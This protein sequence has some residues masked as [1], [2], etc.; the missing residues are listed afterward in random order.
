MSQDTFAA[1]LNRQSQKVLETAE[2]AVSHLIALADALHMPVARDLLEASLDGL[3]RPSFTM[4]IFGR[5]STGKSTLINVLLGRLQRPLQDLPG[6]TGAPLPMDDMPVNARV[7]T[8]RYA[9][10]PT[11]T[12][13]RTDGSRDKRSLAWFIQNSPLRATHQ[14]SIDAFRDI[15]QFELTYPFENGKAGIILVDTPG[16]DEA[17]ERDIVALKA[18][19][20]ADAAILMFQTGGLAGKE[21]LSFARRMLDLGLTSYFTVINRWNGK[22]IDE[23]F[24]RFAWDK[25]VREL[26]QGP[27]FAADRFAD[28]RVYFVDALAA[29][30]GRLNDD[31]AK[32]RAS[33]IVELESA[34]ARFYEV[35]RRKV[36][37]Q[38]WADQA[39][40]QAAQMSSFIR[41]QIPHLTA[42]HSDFQRSYEEAGPRLKELTAR[43]GQPAK[44]FARFRDRAQATLLG[45]LQQLIVRISDEIG[46]LLEKQELKSVQGIGAILWAAMSKEKKKE[47]A[48]EI[49]KIVGEYSAMRM[50]EWEKAEPPKPGMR[51]LLDPLVADL[52]DDLRSEI[53]R[54]ERD[55]GDLKLQLSGRMPTGATANAQPEDG[56]WWTRVAPAALGL[57]FGP[58]M[59]AT[60]LRD[61]WKGFG[62]SFV[63]H[64]AMA[65][66]LGALSLFTPIGWGVLIGAWIAAFFTRTAWRGFDLRNEIKRK[67]VE[68]FIDGRTERLEQ[69]DGLIREAILEMT[70]E[71]EA[72]VTGKFADEIRQQIQNIE[73]MRRVSL[74]SRDEK[75][76]KIEVYRKI[77]KDLAEDVKTLNYV[78]SMAAV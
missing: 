28:Q 42:E 27:Q 30:E 1:G 17:S 57:V 45:S 43:Q 4:I 52:V 56:E 48:D 36:H 78:H 23:R 50:Q 2:P 40:A 60:A 15:E 65:I 16:T 24:M 68:A 46:P 26:K 5:F 35:E 34:L 25:V 77:D 11:V 63:V 6:R 31:E 74:L 3:R 64:I 8:I 14:E 66:G 54:T 73:E 39:L 71:L 12:V 72:A 29:L 49:G 20:K 19:S 47:I 51:S 13:V 76:R 33:G 53:N 61:G 37:V 69:A 7:T 10:E 21:E 18:L 32:V 58:D 9:E 59:A 41:E 62:K 70:K 67:A 38:R 22:L 55:F 75:A 44:I